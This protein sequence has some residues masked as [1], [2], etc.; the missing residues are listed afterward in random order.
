MLEEVV[1]TGEV[2]LFDQGECYWRSIDDDWAGSDTQSKEEER[3]KEGCENHCQ[4]GIRKQQ[5][6]PME[7]RSSKEGL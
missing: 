3:E 4:A 6:Q 1:D 7:F 5:Q 2:I